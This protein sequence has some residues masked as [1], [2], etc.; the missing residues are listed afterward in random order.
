MP[1]PQLDRR[2]HQR[3]AI[4]TAAA[5]RRTRSK[6]SVR[7]PKH[8]RS[9]RR[10]PPRGTIVHDYT[11]PAVFVGELD[12]HL[13]CLLLPPTIE[14]KRYR[15]HMDGADAHSTPT[16]SVGGR[17]IEGHRGTGMRAPSTTTRPHPPAMRPHLRGRLASRRTVARRTRSVVRRVASSSDATARWTSCGRPWRMRSRDVDGVPLLL[18]ARSGSPGLLDVLPGGGSGRCGSCGWSHP[19]RGRLRVYLTRRVHIVASL[20]TPS[21]AEE[22]RAA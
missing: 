18:H 4:F 19:V 6:T 21:P 14:T 15:T 9:V 8:D 7:A 5:C 2:G 12:W 17:L 11:V 3:C 22:C 16:A 10:E 13:V 1:R 20:F